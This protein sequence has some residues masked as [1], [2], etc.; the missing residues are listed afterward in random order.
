[1]QFAIRAPDEQYS[2]DDGRLGDGRGGLRKSKCPFQL[3][4]R[5]LA[6]R[7]SCDLRRL[8]AAVVEI[9]APAVPLQAVERAAKS[10][11]AV[12][13]L[14]WAFVSNGRRR[15]AGNS[16]RDKGGDCFAL[17]IRPFFG[18]VRHAARCNHSE[19]VLKRHQLQRAAAGYAA[20]LIAGVVAR[21]AM[22]GV[23]SST[24]LLRER[25]QAKRDKQDGGCRAQFH[26][27]S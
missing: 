20:L 26:G 18:H 13:T 14:H 6:W 17:V 11:G 3:Q 7:Q 4:S 16:T 21:R 12:G 5:H 1:V 10:E 25:R 23:K 27:S 19:N 15:I 8:K 2:A 9:R 24:A 22:L